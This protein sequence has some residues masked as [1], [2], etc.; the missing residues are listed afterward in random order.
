MGVLGWPGAGHR[1]IAP[2]AGSP[3]HSPRWDLDAHGGEGLVPEDVV[4]RFQHIKRRH[5]HCTTAARSGGRWGGEWAPRPG[6]GPWDPR[7]ASRPPHRAGQL[8]QVTEVRVASLQ[9][10]STG[11]ARAGA[12]IGG[13]AGPGARTPPETP[14]KPFVPPPAP[15]EAGRTRLFRKCCCEHPVT[16][17]AKRTCDHHHRHQD[18]G[19]G[20]EQRTWAPWSQPWRSPAALQEPHRPAPRPRQEG[21]PPRP[22]PLARRGRAEVC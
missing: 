2:A 3:G 19:P 6:P 11:T 5:L 7:G 18:G 16:T 20:G 4:L 17:L 9:S 12:E 8:R 21:S 14:W 22:P 13:E 15:P 10:V 1:P